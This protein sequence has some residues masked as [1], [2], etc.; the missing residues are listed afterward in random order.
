MN[1]VNK[2]QTY[3]LQ[4]WSGTVIYAS[5]LQNSSS[6]NLHQILYCLVV[7]DGIGLLYHC[8]FFTLKNVTTVVRRSQ[9][10]EY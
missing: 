5:V 9:S 3:K 7:S 8:C 4:M 1:S 2:L 6:D 10:G